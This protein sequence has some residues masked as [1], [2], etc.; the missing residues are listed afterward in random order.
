MYVLDEERQFENNNGAEDGSFRGGDQYEGQMSGGGRMGGQMGEGQMG[1]Q[2]GGGQMRGQ[3]GG[4]Q[5]G[6]H[7]H[8][9]IDIDYGYDYGGDHDDFGQVYRYDMGN[10]ERLCY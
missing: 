9:A 10:F 2:M 5:L 7:L 4:G 3:F 6:G 1:E 8:G